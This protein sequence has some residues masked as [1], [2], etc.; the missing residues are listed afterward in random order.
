MADRRRDRRQV[1]AALF[2]TLGL[3][4]AFVVSAIAGLGDDGDGPASAG[5]RALGDPAQVRVE[6]LNGA[7]TAGVARAA[8]DRLRAAG[9]DVVFFGNAARFDH[10]RSAVLA[11]L[12]DLDR[13]RA[14]AASL[15]IDSVTVALDSSLLLDVTVLLGDDWPP[16][17]Q[18]GRGVIERVKE[19]VGGR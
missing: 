10:P 18:E 1:S 4:G 11:R 15:G 6:V 17:P 5:P 3:V 8:T 19:L 12:G 16:A 2:V 7:G 14:V 9:F 13:A